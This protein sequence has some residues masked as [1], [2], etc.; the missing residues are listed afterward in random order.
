MAENRRS[1]IHN[2]L[3]V[4]ASTVDTVM[5]VADVEALVVTWAMT[6]STAAGQLTTPEVRLKVEGVVLPT[7]LTPDVVHALVRVAPVIAAV[8]RYDLRGLQ[9]DIQISFTTTV[10]NRTV[11]VYTNSYRY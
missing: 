5:S 2:A 3:V 11:K 1:T 7:V 10:A 6:D 4:G 9:G 8:S